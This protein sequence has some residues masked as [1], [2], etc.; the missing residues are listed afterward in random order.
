MKVPPQAQAPSRGGKEEDHVRRISSTRSGQGR[1]RGRKRR[2][3]R[4]EWEERRMADPNLVIPPSAKLPSLE[5]V[6]GELE[7]QPTPDVTSELMQVVRTIEKVATTAK[8]LSG[9][10]VR[11][12]RSAAL[13]IHAGLSIV[14]YRA[15]VERG[16]D[17][18]EVAS[19]R[20]KVRGLLMEKGRMEREVEQAV[21]HRKEADKTMRENEDLRR[22]VGRLGEGL[23]EMKGRLVDVMDG[24]GPA[25]RG[26]DMTPPPR[27]ARLLPCCGWLLPRW[28][29]GRRLLVLALPSSSRSRGC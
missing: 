14:A 28:M 5:V 16:G 17:G 11:R 1:E 18:E 15:Q 12:L 24:A 29:G 9:Q 4:E 20:K 27:R 19:L 22:R 10:Y 3:E 8:N 7:N 25:G 26:G 21:Q 2:R 23:R 6:M 13:T